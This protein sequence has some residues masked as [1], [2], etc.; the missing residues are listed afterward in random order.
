[1]ERIGLA[2]GGGGVRGLAHA[3]AL[4]ILDD[5]GFR[6][7]AIAGTSMGAIVGALYASGLSGRDILDLVDRHVI[8]RGDGLREIVRKKDSL[9]K[10]L[11]ALRPSWE[12]GLLKAEGVLS[13]L[14]DE[15]P[16]RTFE[17]LAIP[18]RVVATDFR[19]GEAVLF[20]SGELIPAL[21][22]SMAIPGIFAPV[23]HEG[24]RLVDGGL[25]DNLPYHVLPDDCDRTIAI[26]VGSS[27]ETRGGEDPGIVDAIL[28]MFDI[29]LE[30]QT[31]ARLAEAPPTLLVH[32]TFRG[33]RILEFE[34][35]ENVLDQAE[36]T[37]EEFRREIR[38]WRK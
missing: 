13:L 29:M 1:M 22:A 6:P 9:F 15:I 24:R 10:W 28:G 2:L 30:R 35:I 12:G 25:V 18:L 27:P 32:P 37:M 3:R 5:E 23:E 31:A 20:E 4:D 7:S 36:E 38:G 26:D 34:K 17:E 11:S 8:Q 33:I 16:S 14:I 21:T 19:R